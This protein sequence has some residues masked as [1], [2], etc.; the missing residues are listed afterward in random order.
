MDGGRELLQLLVR[1][2]LLVVELDVYFTGEGRLHGDRVALC[3][4][5]RRV[6]HARGV[7]GEDVGRAVLGGC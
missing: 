7:A 2:T 5:F 1:L 4:L 3:A 6:V